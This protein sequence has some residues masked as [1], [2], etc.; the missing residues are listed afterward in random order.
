MKKPS[1]L[2]SLLVAA[3]FGAVLTISSCG[4]SKITAEE[5][6]R[7]FNASIRTTAP[8]F[9]GELNA[10]AVNIAKNWCVEHGVGDTISDGTAYEENGTINVSLNPRREKEYG[11]EILV[12]LDPACTE[13]IR[14]V[15]RKTESVRLTIIPEKTVI[16]GHGSGEITLASP[17]SYTKAAYAIPRPYVHIEGRLEGLYMKPFQVRCDPAVQSVR[18]SVINLVKK[19]ITLRKGDVVA[20]LDVVYETVLQDRPKSAEDASVPDYVRAFDPE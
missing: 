3:L 7:I 1:I 19:D 11:Y 20:T 16:P 18:Y 5:K 2:T 4:T 17:R 13:V 6:N 15:R 12:T 14:V 10:T 9:R 8:E